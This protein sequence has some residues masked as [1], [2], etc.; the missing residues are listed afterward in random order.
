MLHRVIPSALLLISL[1][2][3]SFVVFPAAAQ[4]GYQIVIPDPLPY[5]YQYDLR[6]C[7]SVDGSTSM[8]S[9]GDYFDSAIGYA[10]YWRINVEEESDWGSISV[11]TYSSSAMASSDF[12]KIAGVNYQRLSVAL[13][14]YRQDFKSLYRL[15]DAQM[16][17]FDRLNRDVPDVL[18]PKDGVIVLIDNQIVSFKDSDIDP[19]IDVIIAIYQANIGR[20]SITVTP[21]GTSYPAS[22]GGVAND[23]SGGSGVPEDVQTAESSGFALSVALVAFGLVFAVSYRR[24][25]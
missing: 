11:F 5:G 8:G 24:L 13:S 7:K 19:F 17:L 2:I 25:R 9:L 10:Y 1:L 6:S 22:S 4:E 18:G 20:E 15:S 23:N 16:A 3:G 21:T 12:N 14:D